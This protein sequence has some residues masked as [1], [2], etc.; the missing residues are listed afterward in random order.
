MPSWA[1]RVNMFGLLKQLDRFTVAL[2]HST[3]SVARNILSAF[4][5]RT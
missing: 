5:E 3:E 2:G 4:A 1:L